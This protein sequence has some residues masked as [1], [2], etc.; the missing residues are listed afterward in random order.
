MEKRESE[1]YYRFPKYSAA[2]GKREAHE[3]SPLFLCGD[4]ST[5]PVG[6]DSLACFP[7]RILFFSHLDVLC[8][9]FI[10]ACIKLLADTVGLIPLLKV[11]RINK[12]TI[13]KV[14]RWYSGFWLYFWWYWNT[15]S[16]NSHLTKVWIVFVVVLKSFIWTSKPWDSSFSF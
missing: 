1:Y 16:L 2:N 11:I 7:S 10:H 14:P 9:H 5:G 8:K 12:M 3:G 4:I 15:V 6:C 13:L